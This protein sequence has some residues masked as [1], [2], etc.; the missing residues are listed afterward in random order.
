MPFL[1]LKQKDKVDDGHNTP[2]HCFED[3]IDLFQTERN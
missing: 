1:H 3:M 2:H